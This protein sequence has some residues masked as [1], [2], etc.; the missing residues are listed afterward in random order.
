MDAQRT[1]GHLPGT[2]VRRAGNGLRH[3]TTQWTSPVGVKQDANDGWGDTPT[4]STPPYYGA[5]SSGK[6]LT[7][8][9]ISAG[10]TKV[11]LQRR[12]LSVVL[13]CTSSQGGG[14]GSGMYL[15][16]IAQFDSRNVAIQSDLEP[17]FYKDPATGGPKQNTRIPS[18]FMVADT[19]APDSSGGGTQQIGYMPLYLRS[20]WGTGSSYQWQF[21][22]GGTSI[23]P[24]SG[25]FN[26]L[27]YDVS[28]PVIRYY[29]TT[30]GPGSS[31]YVTLK[32]TDSKDGAIASNN[33]SILFH[34]AYE[35]WQRKMTV[36][37]PVALVKGGVNDVH[38]DWTYLTTISN[39]SSQNLVHNLTSAVTLSTTLTATIS[40]Q[41]T[42]TPAAIAAFQLNE[43]ISVGKTYTYAYTAQNTFTGAPHTLTQFFA[44]M[45][46]ESR[47]GTSDVY[48]K[49]GFQGNFGWQGI[50]ASGV[51][52]PG[53]LEWPN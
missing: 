1:R 25:T 41:Q 30:N 37:Y 20:S 12:D 38:P 26:T 51:V 15:K 9:T 46:Y 2:V 34:G 19:V 49:N 31:E 39:G 4:F 22:S 5:V 10:Q 28:S 50:W 24:Q 13:S 44:A 27:L 16:Y 42:L 17:T 52:S 33:Y 32:L 3:S 8:V 29:L 48:A 18:G 35:Q 23:D 14:R 36:R 40:G 53:S 47:T 7:H 6:H 45:S 43:S 21:S 11:P